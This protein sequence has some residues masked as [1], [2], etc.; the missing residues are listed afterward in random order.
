MVIFVCVWPEV[1]PDVHAKANY[2]HT[3][4]AHCVTKHPGSGRN[5]TLPDY[6][7]TTPSHLLH[8]HE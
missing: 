8:A 4:H 2:V 7:I 3:D 1:F 5:W 6:I